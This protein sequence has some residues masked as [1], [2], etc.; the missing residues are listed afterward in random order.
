MTGG[1]LDFLEFAAAV[2]LAAPVG[3]LG[4]IMITNG[5][6][7]GG[8][9]FL[10]VAAGMLLLDRLVLAPREVVANVLTGLGGRVT[11]TEDD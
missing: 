6:A 7:V 5:D 10:G 11:D 4:V 8:L 1:L 9:A 2:V 3:L